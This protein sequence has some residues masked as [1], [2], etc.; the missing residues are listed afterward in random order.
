MI[1]TRLTMLAQEVLLEHQARLDRLAQA[2][3]IAQQPPATEAAQSDLGGPDLVVK[4][5]KTKPLQAEQLVKTGHE[6]QPLGL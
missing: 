3:L 2:N 6:R 4:R 1:S 5:D